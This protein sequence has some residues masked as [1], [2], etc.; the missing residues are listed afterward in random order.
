MAARRRDELEL[1]G[2][3]GNLRLLIPSRLR[4]GEIPPE[5]KAFLEKASPIMKDAGIIVDLR[6][7]GWSMR[8][9]IPV[10]ERIISPV[11]AK[12]A[13]WT[14]EAPETL[15]WMNGTGLAMHTRP[16]AGGRKGRSHGTFHQV[17]LV[18]ESLRSGRKI[19][20]DGEVIV[21][22]NVN[23]G[24]E[25]IAGGSV[26]VMGRLRGLAH[27]GLGREDDAF[28][29]AGQ[30]EANLVRIGSKISYIDDSCSWWG[31]SVSM[32]ISKGTIAVREISA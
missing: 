5:A 1:R 6:G 11:D 2:E 14:A 18:E 28:I 10:V 20:H 15:S 31:K 30:F 23:D 8:D 32:R 29:V 9:I 16:D 24:A 4:R 22:G 19:E 25:V 13:A 26:V 21:L 27:A 12:V 7:E 17:L 3:G